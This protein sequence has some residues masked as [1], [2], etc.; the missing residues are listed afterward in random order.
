[1][2][3]FFLVHY[4]PTCLCNCG[5][6]WHVELYL[7]LARKS[8]INTNDYL[9][10]LLIGVLLAWHKMPVKKGI[11][12]KVVEERRRVIRTRAPVVSLKFALVQSEDDGHNYGEGSP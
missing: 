3:L 4:N 2:G 1:M 11:Q 7:H 9:V 6:V 10:N 5:C 8:F 12:G